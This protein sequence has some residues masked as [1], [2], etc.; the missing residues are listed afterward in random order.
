[1]FALLVRSTARVLPTLQR[2]P[3]K[4]TNVRDWDSLGITVGFVGYTKLQ[5]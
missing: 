5:G 4:G 2:V 1:M 3:H